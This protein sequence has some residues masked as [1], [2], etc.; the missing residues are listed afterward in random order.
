[1]KP[2]ELSNKPS[3]KP[4]GNHNMN[5]KGKLLKGNTEECSCSICES[6]YLDKAFQRSTIKKAVVFILAMV[7]LV[8][9]SCRLAHA[10]GRINDRDA[11]LAIIGEGEAE[12]YIGKLALA[13]TL[14]NRGTLKGVYGLHAP[15]VV[16]HKYSKS[17]YEDAKRAW[18]YANANP[19]GDWSATGW[20]NKADMVLFNKTKWFSK[21]H[22]TDHIGGHWFYACTTN[23]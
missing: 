2:W 11:V 7:L 17:T 15:R 21:C 22:V 3:Q 8:V 10:E 19:R 14:I 6:I 18:E 1:M 13:Y 23:H 5:A 16:K 4:K 9:A 20:G 12:P